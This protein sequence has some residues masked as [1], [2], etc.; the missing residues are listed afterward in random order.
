MASQIY[1]IGDLSAFPDGR[2]QELL[3]T[4]H[5]ALI[6]E[7]GNIAL[8][9]GD[10]DGD[11]RTDDYVVA[12]A[13]YSSEQVAALIGRNEEN[14]TRSVLSYV[15]AAVPD[16]NRYFWDPGWLISLAEEEDKDFGVVNEQTAPPWLKPPLGTAKGPEFGPGGKVLDGIFGFIVDYREK[17]WQT[18]VATQAISYLEHGYSGIFLDD[19]GRYDETDLP[20]SQA[21]EA[22]MRLVVN[23]QDEITRATGKT[24]AELEIIINSDSFIISNYFWAADAPEVFDL[25]LGARFLSVVDGLVMEN[26]TMDAFREDDP[27]DFWA[28]ANA[29]FVGEVFNPRDGA[30]IATDQTDLIAIESPLPWDDM[31][32]VLELLLARGVSL[33]LSPNPAYNTVLN[34]PVIGTIASESLSGTALAE[35]FFGRGGVDAITAGG[36]DDYVYAAAGGGTIY[37]GEGDDV[38]YGG[39]G[40]DVMYGGPG[41]DLIY[42]GPGNDTVFVGGGNDTILGGAGAD[43]IYGDIGND[44]LL[45]D[46]GPDDMFGGDGQDTIS[47]GAGGDAISAGSG[48]D[49][50]Y[51]GALPDTFAFV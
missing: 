41:D 44:V 3:E 47:G 18:I 13:R 28:T 11:G 26:I 39:P 14:A 29:Y 49:L 12:T 21:A 22:M 43:V 15:N 37:A 25:D 32:A 27:V 9:T 5:G 46:G 1:L 20:A 8:D 16:H 36:G 48:A 30:F 40:D 24:A 34:S 38:I 4:Q 31:Q 23:V 50:I 35:A 42:A 6:L 19:V 17:G 51:G 2:T 10:A 33:F 45:G 7:A